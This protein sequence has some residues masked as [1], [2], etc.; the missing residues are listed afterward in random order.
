[1]YRTILVP[2][3]GSTFSERALPIAV[4]LQRL[5]GARLVLVRAANASVIPGTDP[6]H[7][8]CQAIDEATAYMQGVADLLEQ[9]GVRTE[10]AVPYGEAAEA[11][12]LEIKLW[13]ADLVVM[14]THGRS[15]LG[16][17]I[18]GSVAENLLAH[19]STP[20]LLVRPTGAPVRLTDGPEPPRLIVP[21]DGSPFAEAALPYAL[22]LACALGAGLEL[23]QVVTPAAQIFPE[24]VMVSQVAVEDAGRLVEEDCARASA[25]LAEVAAQLQIDGPDIHTS[26]QVGHP[27]DVI[28]HEAQATD[29]RLLVLATHG[30]TGLRR[31]LM[32]SVAH[33]IVHRTLLPV[34]L[35]HP[36]NTG[37][38]GGVGA[39]E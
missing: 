3:D 24:Q 13:Q 17:W 14:C 25:Y 21:L 30:R 2:L 29:A 7:A 12:R 11:I 1:M 22:D 15:G 16:R 32:G 28:L 4:A 9:Q 37:V 27:A 8:Q 18:Y 38:A 23:L 39:A 33:E 20:I 10:V 35:V 36:D 31:L 26:V 34:L 19:S 6:T 5:L